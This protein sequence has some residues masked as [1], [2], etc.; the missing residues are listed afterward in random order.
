M[1]GFIRT[2]QEI[3]N[4]STFGAVIVSDRGLYKS[5]ELVVRRCNDCGKMHFY[6]NMQ[7]MLS[8]CAN[9]YNI[10]FRDNGPTEGT[11]APNYVMENLET[12]EMTPAD[13]LVKALFGGAAPPNVTLSHDPIEPP[14]NK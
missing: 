11:G 1:G 6:G 8:L 4:H 2:K 9:G 3:A 13:D 5:I 14:E 10:F 12:G 7:A